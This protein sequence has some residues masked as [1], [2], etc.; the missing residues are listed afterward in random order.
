MYIPKKTTSVGE[1]K[2]KIIE[3]LSGIYDPNESS[4][5]ASILIAYYTEISRN[6]QITNRNLPIDTP[7]V[8]KINLALQRLIDH[9]PLQ[10][11]LGFTEFFGKSFKVNQHVLIPRPETEELCAWISH[12]E[13]GPDSCL[14]IGTGSGCIAITLKQMFPRA[15]VWGLDVSRDALETA[16]ENAADH[17]LELYWICTDILKDQ[18][19]VNEPLELI[20][21]NPPYVTWSEQHEM[22]RNVIDHEPDLA[23]FV[24]DDDPLVFYRIIAEKCLPKLKSRGRIYFEI[25]PKYS[26]ALTALF[27][28]MDFTYVRTRKDF[29][30]KCRFIQLIK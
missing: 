12:E 6:S 2:S 28:K 10:Y 1:I 14:D 15:K 26:D 23:L 13:S 19:S 24:P 5:L 3:S 29:A 27:E 21:S 7:S 25:N 20:V 17:N 4:S 11:V 16:V 8:Q 9:E 30:G 22:S 18:V